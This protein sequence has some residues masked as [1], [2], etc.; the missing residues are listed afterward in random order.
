MLTDFDSAV[1]YLRSAQAALSASNQPDA[2]AALAQANRQL[3]NAD[4]AAQKYGMP[5]LNS[6]PAHDST[7]APAGP[8]PSATA[9]AGVGWQLRH[10]SPMAVQQVNATV[11]DGQVWIAGGLTTP[12][13]ATTST[14]FY[15]PTIDSWGLGPPLPQAI[16]H[17]MLVTYRGQLTIIGG[18]QT[19]G[20]DA[21]ATTS[22]RVLILD[23]NTGRWMDAQPL[24]HPRAAGAAAVIGDKLIVVG[25]RTGKPEQL[26]P[27]TEIYD[28]TNWHDAANIPIPGD[29]LAATSDPTY[30][31]AVG[32]RK[33][34]AATNTD[35]IQ[36]YDPATDH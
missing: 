13:Q 3:M 6:C 19:N 17:A 8:S 34:T 9:P 30:L 20:N 22:S 12:T 11:L 27:Q 4:A 16:H 25:G 15:D 23:N 21:L 31:Y 35:A 32:G 36:R 18:F 14:Q 26:V 29:H 10:E 5:P 7:T 33:F 24:H 28:G 1:E 2:D